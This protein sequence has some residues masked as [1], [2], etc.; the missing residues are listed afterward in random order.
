MKR[1]IIS[2]I[3]PV[4]NVQQYLEETIRSVQAQTFSDYEVIFVDDAST[5][6]SL[7]ILNRTAEADLRFRVLEQKKGGAGA[8]RNLGLSQARGEYVIFLDSDDLFSPV[9]LEKLYTAITEAQADIAA[10]NFSRLNVN[11]VETQHEGVHVK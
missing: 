9:L 6:A 3:M 4:Y 11:G 1:P 5:D 8:A 10:C 2:V 7:T